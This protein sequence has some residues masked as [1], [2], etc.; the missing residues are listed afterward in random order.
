MALSNAKV[1]IR[2]Y[3]PYCTCDATSED[4]RNYSVTPKLQLTTIFIK[5]R[6]QGKFCKCP[7]DQVRPQTE[8]AND[9]R[10]SWIK[11]PNCTVSVSVASGLG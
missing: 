8:A 11:L 4:H 7:K 3:E 5:K 10:L 1:L 2:T 9:P 6:R